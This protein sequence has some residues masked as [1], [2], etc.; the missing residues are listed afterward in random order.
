M[1]QI[2]VESLVGLAVGALLI[3]GVLLTFLKSAK[4]GEKLPHIPTKDIEE[5]IAAAQPEEAPPKAKSLEKSTPDLTLAPKS[6]SDAL[7]NTRK[8]F[9]GRIQNAFAGKSQIGDSE[10]EEI[11]EVL[12][13]S[14][15]GPKTVQRL[16]M[17]LTDRVQKEK[18][19][20][21]G[22]RKFL[23]DEMIQILDLA[24]EESPL[25]ETSQGTPTIWMIV[26]VNGAGKTTTIGK[27]ANRLSKDGK[28]V[29]IAAGDT[30]RA[31][32]KEQLA[33]WSQ[34]ANVEIFAPEGVDNPSGIAF[35]ATK[36]AVSEGFEYLILDTA[37][38]LHTQ[39]NL[40]EELKKVKRVVEKAHVGSPHETL[41]VL[42][43]NQ[44][45]NA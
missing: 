15:L 3:G 36:K 42:D 6:L 7:S 23:H 9:F 12:Y 35:D 16:M 44:G 32:A 30:F 4:R 28:K 14:D 22:V 11:E 37:G 13:T 5:A 39:K 27:L 26:G 19:N 29:L 8:G 41:L 31:A 1:D 20:A 40:M 34:R 33:V 38:R 17:T 10:I 45:Q 21:D 43:S 25:L 24:K 18:L 2:S